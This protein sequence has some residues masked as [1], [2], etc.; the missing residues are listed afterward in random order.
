MNIV[1][2][3]DLEVEVIKKDIK[4]IHLGVY[5]PI[6]RVRLSA[7]L[8]S[9]NEKIRLFIVSKIPWIRK[10]QRK[11][12]NKERQSP[13]LYI[14]RESHY[15]EGQRYL[16]MLNVNPK[17]K[18]SVVLKK[19]TIELK[20][21]AEYDSQKRKEILES[22]LRGN[23]RSR[24]IPFIEKWEKQLGV[25]TKECKIKKMKTKWGS[26]NQQA[27]RIW[28][29]LE[30]E[31]VDDYG[32]DYVVMHELAHLKVRNHG[33]QFIKILDQNMSDWHQRKQHLNQTLLEFNMSLM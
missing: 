13:R 23:L 28:F 18:N 30:L 32:L 20:L 31:K 6:G 11:F 25:K 4:N 15:F 5:P 21:K 2:V 10:N 16:L 24:L 1:N 26:C 7:P 14:N 17:N 12:K 8:S 19:T 33:K 9:D 22:W 3:G 27:K 29:N